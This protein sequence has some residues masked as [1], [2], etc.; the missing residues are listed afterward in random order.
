MWAVYTVEADSA[1]KL[2][3]IK[4]STGE[5]GGAS[6]LFKEKYL[7]TPFLVGLENL[8]FSFRICLAFWGYC[9]AFFFFLLYPTFNNIVILYELRGCS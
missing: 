5:G 8:L 1:K 6:C 9:R 4:C 7:S 2:N 3:A